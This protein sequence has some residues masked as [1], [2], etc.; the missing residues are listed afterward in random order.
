M[1]GDFNIEQEMLY[2]LA[3]LIEKDPGFLESIKDAIS[4]LKDKSTQEYKL[5]NLF[6]QKDK[7]VFLN[8]ED[9][10]DVFGPTSGWGWKDFYRKFPG[11]HGTI[12]FSRVGFNAEKTRGLLYVHSGRAELASSGDYY[13]LDKKEGRWTIVERICVVVS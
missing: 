10:E 4:D 12:G 11:S 7:C 3:V 5:K 8:D 9:S 13:V 6:K 2:D 1:D